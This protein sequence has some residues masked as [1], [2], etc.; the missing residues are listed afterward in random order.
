M[1]SRQ[2]P[3][4]HAL[5]RVGSAELVQRLEEARRAANGR[6]LLAFDADG[7]LWSG[8][9]GFD[10]FKAALAE[11]ALRPEARDALA[12]EAHGAGLSAEPGDDANA[13][14]LRL[15]AAWAAGDYDDGR[16]FR[17][18]AWAFAGHDTASMQSLSERALATAGVEARIHAPVRAVIDWAHRAEVEVWIVSA[19]PRAVVEAGGRLLAVPADRV[20]AVTPLREG[21]RLLASLEEPVPY[22]VGKPAALLA[23]A[24]GATVL[25]AFGDSASDGPMM[26]LARIAVAVE[27]HPRLRALCAELSHLVELIVDDAPHPPAPKP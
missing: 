2:D 12:A 9:V 16:A 20:L 24:A 3:V 25:G 1:S 4:T 17:M 14:A 22:D 26:R 23:A 10:L 15:F 8:D 11:R 21:D 5:P 6:A 27:P 7:T 13:I 18:M 19:S